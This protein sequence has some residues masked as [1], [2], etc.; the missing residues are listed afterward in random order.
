MI[1]SDTAIGF[2]CEGSGDLDLL[3]PQVASSLHERFVGHA[4]SGE[5]RLI[6]NP[7]RSGVELIV[8][9][10]ADDLT[11]E[12]AADLVALLEDHAMRPLTDIE[13]DDAINRATRGMRSGG[14]R[15]LGKPPPRPGHPL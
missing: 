7:V 11:T 15:L 4:V 2:L 10:P 14:G 1:D 12:A 13:L 3:A 5:W 9:L 6:W 8:A